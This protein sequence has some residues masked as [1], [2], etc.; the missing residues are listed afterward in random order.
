M[1]RKDHVRFGGGQ[2]EKEPSYL[3]RCLPYND[4]LRTFPTK[5]ADVRRTLAYYDLQAFAPRVKAT[6]LLMTGAPGS[7]PDAPALA[8]LVT[9]LPSPVTVHESEQS[10]YKDGLYA[11]QWMADRCGISDVQRILPE[12]W[13]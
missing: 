13:R 8:P 2:G 12:H 11:E 5:A 6:T 9:A 10:S 4:Y 1:M 7:L 3:A